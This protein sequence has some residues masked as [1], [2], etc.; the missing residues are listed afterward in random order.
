MNTN[1]TS[2]ENDVILTNKRLQNQEP[3][4]LHDKQVT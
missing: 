2:I 3:F 4:S 1:W